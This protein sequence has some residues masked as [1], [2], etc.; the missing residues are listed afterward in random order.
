M[1]D[2][3][4]DMIRKTVRI[5]QFRNKFPEWL[6]YLMTILDLN[7]KTKSTFKQDFEVVRTN[8]NVFTFLTL[9]IE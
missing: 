1:R 9:I 2:C 6:K 7:L 5:K 8:L 3:S 4:E